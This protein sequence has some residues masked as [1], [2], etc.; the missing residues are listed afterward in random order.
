MNALKLMLVFV[1]VLIAGCDTSEVADDGE[2]SITDFYIIG[3]NDNNQDTTPIIDPYDNS[4]RFLVFIGTIKPSI[5]YKLSLYLSSST[6]VKDSVSIF[7]IECDDDDSTCYDSE[8][9]ALSCTYLPDLTGQCSGGSPY[10]LNGQINTIPYSG[11]IIAKL[12][13]RVE[14]TCAVSTQQ[15]VFL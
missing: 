9:L 2:A 4:G 15:L 1:L 6:S 11:Y 13:H 3:S 14:N 12:C 5:G 7:Y 10:D 8:Y